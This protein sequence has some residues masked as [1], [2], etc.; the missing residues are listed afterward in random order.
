MSSLSP[1]VA[2]V[3]RIYKWKIT[4]SGAAIHGESSY[5]S[6]LYAAAKYA[7]AKFTIKKHLW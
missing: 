6:S 3:A 5:T 1:T 2:Q 4:E 7:A